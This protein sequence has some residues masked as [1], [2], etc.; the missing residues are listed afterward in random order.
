MKK[1]LIVILGFAV[2]AIIGLAIYKFNFTNDDIYME[3]QSGLE[4]PQINSYDAT[5]TID[6]EK[7][8]LENGMSSVQV[9]PNSAS[10]KTTKYFG[11]DFKYDLDNDEREDTV[12]ILT[13]ETGGSGTFYYVVALLDKVNGKVGSEGLLLGDR[14]SPVSISKGD[15]KIIVVDYKDRK[16]EESFATLPTEEKSI[17]LVLDTE[18]MQFGEVAQNFEGEADPERMTLGMKTWDW[19]NTKY[20]DY[21]EVKPKT[22]NKFTLTFK[23]DKT[24]SATTDCN[25]VGGEYVTKENTIT[26]KNMI[27]TLM[28]CEGSQESQFTKMLNETQSYFFTS[29][30]E[31]VLE[32]KFDSGSAVF[33]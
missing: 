16:P 22:D 23:D 29:K 14:I 10:Q 13:Q 28:F 17:W 21:T 9:A 8:T 6:G 25:N 1:I 32:F 20:N 33:K 5:Y 2:L 12:F 31:L 18:T 30:G 7:V 24:F 19:V 15:Y 3:N 27:S 26:F 11:N 4:N